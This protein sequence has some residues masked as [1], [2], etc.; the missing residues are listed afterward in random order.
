MAEK[1]NVGEV[2]SIT[3]LPAATDAKDGDVLLIHD[4][5]AAKKITA[6]D[7]LKGKQDKGDFATNT[8]LADGL[9]KKQ[10]KGDYATNAQL[11]QGLAGKQ[12]KGDYATNSA[13]SA[14]RADVDALKERMGDVTFYIDDSDGGLNAKTLKE[15][16]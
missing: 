4:G 11:T 14:L 9:A 5:T 15:G 10:D 16:Y 7:M 2:I 3:S 1:V 13:V 12:D 6:A 8:A